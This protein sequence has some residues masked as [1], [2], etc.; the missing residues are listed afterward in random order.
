MAKTTVTSDY[1]GY[2]LNTELKT[3]RVVSSAKMIRAQAKRLR[4][5]AEIVADAAREISASF[6]TRIPAS[7]RITGGTSKVYIRAGGPSA[8]NAYPFDTGARHP[9]F[10]NRDWWY[11]Q[12]KKPFLEEAYV[13]TQNEMADAFALVIDD[14]CDELGL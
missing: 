5:A 7:I 1:Q 13:L 11:P 6:S 12:P 14:W 2:S 4:E 8:P 10:G 9:L 3:L